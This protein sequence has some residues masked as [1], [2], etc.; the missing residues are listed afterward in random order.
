MAERK[1]C[2]VTSACQVCRTPSDLRAF[3]LY[4]WHTTTNH[5]YLTLLILLH[6][7]NIRISTDILWRVFLVPYTLVCVNGQNNEVR[8][9]TAVWAHASLFHRCRWMQTYKEPVP[10]K[11]HHKIFV[12]IQIFYT[13][14]YNH[15]YYYYFPFLFNW[16]SVPQ[17]PRVGRISNNINFF[18]YLEQ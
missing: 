12:D 2:S 11:T 17:L 15:Y 13:I 8:V 18:K 14:Y 6:C 7:K 5:T 16:P 10:L 1:D 4:M 3:H 9:H